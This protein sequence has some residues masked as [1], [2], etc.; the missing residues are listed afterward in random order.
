MSRWRYPTGAVLVIACFASPRKSTE[1]TEKRPCDGRSVFKSREV[2]P[3]ERE[4]PA[5]P[6]PSGQWSV[7]SGQCSVVSAQCSVVAKSPPREGEAPAEPDLSAQWSQSTPWEGEAPAEPDVS[8]QCSVLA[9][10]P[11]E[12]E[13]P[14]EP[15]LSAQWSQSPPGRARLPPSRRM[16]LPDWQSVHWKSGRCHSAVCVCGVFPATGAMHENSARFKAYSL[17]MTA[18]VH[19]AVGFVFSTSMHRLRRRPPR[20]P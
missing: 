8:A 19:V 15:D 5:E 3:W 11:W 18:I 9:K 20:T 2:P 7:V 6:D 13:A 17:M 4:A 12:R 1:D 14:A 10:S 16:P